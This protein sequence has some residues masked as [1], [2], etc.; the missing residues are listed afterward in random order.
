MLTVTRALTIIAKY[1]AHV[2]HPNYG[3]RKRG[4]PLPVIAAVAYIRGGKYCAKCGSLDT[5]QLHHVNGEWR[6]YYIGNLQFYCYS[7][8]LNDHQ[9]N[10]QIK[11]NGETNFMNTRINWN[12]VNGQTLMALITEHASGQITTA[13]KDISVSSERYFGKNVTPKALEKAY[14]SLR[15]K[16]GKAAPTKV[17]PINRVTMQRSM[18]PAEAYEFYDFIKRAGIDIR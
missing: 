11:P 14:H 18:T 12:D 3:P 13:C 1:N 7:C 2:N 10:W 17:Q 8:H 6:D 9:G 4:N 16:F 5:P 15:R